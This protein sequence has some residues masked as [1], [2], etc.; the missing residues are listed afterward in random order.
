MISTT[1]ERGIINNFAKDP[2][3]SA[4]EYPSKAQQRR[5]WIMGAVS[6]VFMAGVLALAY[7]VS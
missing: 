1:D 6:T 2:V 4:V 3:A 5:Y 7:A